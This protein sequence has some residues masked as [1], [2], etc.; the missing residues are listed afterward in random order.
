VRIYYENRLVGTTDSDGH[1]LI[2]NLRPYEANRISIE[3]LDLPFDSQVDATTA[4]IAPRFRSGV[5]V[6]F[7][8]DGSRT[9]L[10]SVVSETGLPVPPGA[11][12]TLGEGS[13][14]FPVGLN[15]QVQLRGIRQGDRVVVDTGSGL[16]E[17]VLDIELPDGPMPELGT[18]TCRRR[19]Q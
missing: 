7:P 12:A 19:V 17:F 11:T 15:G 9:A 3:P 18:F 13:R 5:T 6:E 4:T 16:C 2:H 14:R 10:L 1:L 8:V